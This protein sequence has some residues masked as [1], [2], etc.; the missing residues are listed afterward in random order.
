MVTWDT[1]PS[2]VHEYCSARMERCWPCEMRAVIKITSSLVIR[3][4]FTKLQK[5]QNM[6]IKAG[7]ATEHLIFRVTALSR[8][9]RWDHWW[10]WIIW[11][12]HN[13]GTFCGVKPYSRID[14]YRRFG[15]TYNLHLQSQ[16]TSKKKTASFLLVTWLILWLWSWWQ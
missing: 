1:G 6:V 3:N 12:Y 5:Q 13:G 7:L 16:A 14:I 15:V 9:Q 11:D 10:I 2:P 8:R 4:L